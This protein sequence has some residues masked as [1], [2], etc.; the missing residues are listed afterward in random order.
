MKKKL[1]LTI[2]GI[3]FLG[4]FFLLPANRE[5]L[6]D[7]IFDYWKDFGSQKDNLDLHNR[8]AERYE[9][10][11]TVSIEI[12]RSLKK[13]K[14]PPSGLLLIPP[15]TYFDKAGIDYEVPEPAV[16]Y[17][18]TGFRSISASSPDA[19]K[20]TWYTAAKNGKIIVGVF[21]SPAELNDSLNRFKSFGK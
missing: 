6:N 15:A 20:A 9:S 13:L 12:A 5:W 17:Y 3:S 14:F 10:S 2:A 4:L 7:R 21:S 18:F 8:K 11:Y 19:S 16:F 1:L